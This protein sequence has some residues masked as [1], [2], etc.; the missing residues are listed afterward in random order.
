MRTRFAVAA[1]LLCVATQTLA[2][3]PD[4]TTR[5]A[6]R[7]GKL[8]DGRGGPPITNAVILIQGDRITAVGAGLT[9]PANARVIDLSKS[10]VMPGFIDCHTHVTSQPTDYYE[11][12]FRKTPIDLAVMT[13]V[14]AKRT[15]DA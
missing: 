8:I 5:I 10:V 12:I 2:Q 4:S 7:A 13:H 15:L 11:D 14:Y 3:Q 1:T 9:I 6:I